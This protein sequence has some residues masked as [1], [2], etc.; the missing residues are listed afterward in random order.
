MFEQCFYLAGTRTGCNIEYTAFRPTSGLS[1]FCKVI[2]FN[3]LWSWRYRYISINQIIAQKGGKSYRLKIVIQY[4]NAWEKDWNICIHLIYILVRYRK[5]KDIEFLSFILQLFYLVNFSKKFFRIRVIEPY[6]LEKFYQIVT[7]VQFH[8]LLNMFHSKLHTCW[9][10]IK[11]QYKSYI[12]N[13]LMS[14]YNSF[15]IDPFTLN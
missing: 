12:N 9:V 1:L 14:G 13:Y 5:L 4:L 2:V 11:V 15:L 3:W 8:F 7:I 10:S 6:I